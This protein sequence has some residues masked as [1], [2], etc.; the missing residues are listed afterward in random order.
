MRKILVVGAALLTSS[1]VAFGQTQTARSDAATQIVGLFSAVCLR[2]A[3]EPQ[4][5]RDFLKGRNVPELTPEARAIFLRDRKGIGFDAS[6]KVTRLAVV[7]E[8]N[9]VCSVFAGDGDASQIWP[10]IAVAANNQGLQI[11][12]T[13]ESD[14]EQAVERSYR[15]SI[16]DHQFKLVASVNTRPGAAVRVALTLFP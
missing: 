7:S 15:V 12:Q 9:G 6:N 13:G 1:G 11:S 10:L 14:K 2:S 5:V 4:V 8:D 16:K 3:G